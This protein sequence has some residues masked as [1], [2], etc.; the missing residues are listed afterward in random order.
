M[1]SVGV[2]IAALAVTAAGTGYAI[3][4]AG[5]PTYSTP[6]LAS[7]SRQLSDTEAQLLPIERG[8]A[9]AA[10]GGG[11]YKFSLPQG[12]DESRLGIATTGQGWFDA[13]G[14]L[15]SSDQDYGQKALASLQNPQTHGLLGTQAFQ[16]SPKTQQ[17]YQQWLQQNN[18]TGFQRRLN[19]NQSAG[20]QFDP[21]AGLTWRPGTTT[22]NGVPVTKNSDGTYSINFN[23]Y[24]NAE[25][26]ASIANQEA[27]NNLALAQ[28]Y[29]P[30]FIASALKQ[31]QEADP[32]SYA[33]RQEENDLIQQQMN[34]PLNNPVADILNNQ[35]Q[36]QVE[37]GKGLD[38]FDTGVLNNAVEQA[39]KDRNSS[40]NGADFSQPL[41]TGAAGVAR[42]Q[43]GI[44]KGIGELTSGS[45]PEDIA[46][47]KEQQNLAN[48][49][50]LINGQTPTSEFSS[51]SGA[52][53]GPTPQVS[54]SPLPTMGGNT[55][56]TA[57]SA[58]LGAYG[59]SLGIQEN[60]ANPWL[61]GI[62][63]ALNAGNAL[64]QTGYKPFQA[65]GPQ[66]GG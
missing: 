61:A 49:S 57:G 12:V 7:S 37:A 3:S 45:S 25:T 33:A 16:V 63:T 9:A 1:S 43:A 51:L 13:D 41:T 32:Q 27:A 20:A 14:H 47:R 15:V 10:Q 40:G 64:S 59:T 52:Q 22:I 53:R 42:Q 55:A 21:T 23:G 18:N 65:P 56:Q 34:N 24:S 60:Q 8:L 50:A 28:K 66:S 5:N 38:D 31:E 35:V 2:A 36:S 26:Q 11:E 4:G 19:Q 54:G 62:S 6:N 46:Y 44:Q 48:L 30:Q 17:A 39:L 29:D 58:A